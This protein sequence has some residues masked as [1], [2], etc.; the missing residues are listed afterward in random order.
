MKSDL[1]RIM[2][3]EYTIKLP[4][5]RGGGIRTADSNLIFQ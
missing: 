1:M 5:H 3:I 4:G 2:M